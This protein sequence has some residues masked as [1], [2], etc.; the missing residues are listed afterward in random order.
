MGERKR[1]SEYLKTQK[2]DELIA[3]LHEV[4]ISRYR[5]KTVTGLEASKLMSGNF[6]NNARYKI[7]IEEKV[8]LDH[9]LLFSRIL[10]DNQKVSFEENCENYKKMIDDFLSKRTD[11]Q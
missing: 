8:P 10:F 3:T 9:K 4:F 5:N 6:K 7:R 11:K 2:I 1:R